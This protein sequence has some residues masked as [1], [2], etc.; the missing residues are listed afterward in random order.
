MSRPRG[1]GSL[2]VKHGAWYGRWTNEHGRK[3]NR[4]IGSTELLSRAEAEKAFRLLQGREDLHPTPKAAGEYTVDDACA[5]LRRKLAYVG[6]SKSYAAGC[7]RKQRLHIGPAMGE[8]TLDRVTRGDVE[9][10]GEDMIAS[11]GLSPK[12]V[13]N[14]LTFLHQVFE[15]AIDLEW[16]NDNPVRRATRPRRRRKGDADPDLQF[17]TLEELEAVIR[18]IP[19]EVVMPAPKPF[20]KG[21]RGPSPPPPPDVLGPV[22][23]VIV[24]TA[25]LTGLRRSE[26]IGLRWRD[27]D[28]EAQRIRVRNA[29]VRGE[30]SG[31][32]KSDLSRRRSVPMSDQLVAELNAWS[33]RTLFTGSDDLVFAH[34]LLNAPLDGSKVTKKFQAACRE[35]GVRVVRFHDLRHTFATRLAAKGVPLRNIQEWLGHADS[36]T[37]QIY[38]HYAPSAHEVA[39]VNDAFAPDVIAAITPPDDSAE[40]PPQFPGF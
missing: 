21:R 26:L 35:A 23:R 11:K 30:H 12:T 15:H 1:A 19:D 18:A 29:Y 10:L 5:A 31:D 8:K 25:A 33:R 28:W 13:R 17:L 36:K 22:L 24:R 16:T 9:R 40:S 34:P 14:T 20:R 32:G 7:E 3:L 4:R 27:V 38:S 37:T 6:V 2:Y 39:M